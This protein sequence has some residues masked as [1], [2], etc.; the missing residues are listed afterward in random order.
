[1]AKFHTDKQQSFF[2]RPTSFW[3]HR[4]D[5]SNLPEYLVPSLLHFLKPGTKNFNLRIDD[6]VMAEG[7]IGIGSSNQFSNDPFQPI[8]CDRLSHPASYHHSHARQNIFRDSAMDKGK[9]RALDYG[10]CRFHL[11]IFMFLF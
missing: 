3:P 7:H 9:K 1:M 8:P 5:N 10:A 4:S 11:I 2:L 6:A